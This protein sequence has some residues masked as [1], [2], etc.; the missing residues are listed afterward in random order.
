MN[1]RSSVDD[2]GSILPLVLVVSVVLALVVVAIASYAT[3]ALKLGHTVE[4]SGDRVAAAEGGLDWA[5][6]RY[7][8]GLTTCSSGSGVETTDFQGDVNGLNASV[9]CRL[10]GAALPAGSGFSF[11]GLAFRSASM[12]SS[13]CWNFSLAW[14]SDTRSCGRF[15]P[16][17][18][19]STVAR[20]SSAVC[21]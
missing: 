15:G 21:V 9:T 11:V 16:A 8:K 20:S 14:F 6:D 19:G 4:E 2:R 1:H 5:L 12:I 7:S 13:A 17:R 18:L 3:S 10:V